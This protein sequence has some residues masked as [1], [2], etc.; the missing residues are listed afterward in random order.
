MNEKF[1]DW[2]VFDEFFPVDETTRDDEEDRYLID[3]LDY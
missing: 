3:N 2:L 1:E